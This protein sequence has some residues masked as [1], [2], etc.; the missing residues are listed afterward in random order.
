[1]VPP[2]KMCKAICKINLM[3]CPFYEGGCRLP[4]KNTPATCQYS[5]KIPDDQWEK[6][7][8][9]YEEIQRRIYGD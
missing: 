8:I 2:R 4:E 6:A 3:A 1:M 7:Q 5:I 9:E